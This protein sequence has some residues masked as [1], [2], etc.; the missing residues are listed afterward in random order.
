MSQG[1]N[2]IFAFKIPDFKYGLK[3]SSEILENYTTSSYL[4]LDFIR[5]FSCH[6]VKLVSCR[7]KDL[8]NNFQA[9]SS[10]YSAI[11][12]HC[13]VVFRRK[14]KRSLEQ[15]KAIKVL[16]ME[17]WYG[18]SIGRA[19]PNTDNGS[20]I[21]SKWKQQYFLNSHYMAVSFSQDTHT[22]KHAHTHVLPRCVLS[23]CPEYPS[24]WQTS[25]MLTLALHCQ[26]KKVSDYWWCPLHKLA[27]RKRETTVL[28]NSRTITKPAHSKQT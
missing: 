16:L 21:L 19:T 7:I 28:G 13:K 24:L 2:N 20:L 3:F 9:C 15:K 22:Y 6:V 12:I 11:N 17:S 8:H 18:Y 1:Q 23:L 4:N 10:L 26:T 25:G 27:S 14:L 5:Q